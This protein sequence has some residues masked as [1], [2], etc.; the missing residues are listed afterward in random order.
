MAIEEARSLA[1][2]LLPFLI[3]LSY[4]VI[5]VTKIICKQELLVILLIREMGEL[6]KGILRELNSD[7]WKAQ[8]NGL[9]C[10]AIV[11][12]IIV[13]SYHI[14]IMGVADFSTFIVPLFYNLLLIYLLLRTYR[15]SVAIVS[16]HTD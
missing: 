15:K 12:C 16:I 4:T 9:V 3:I 5:E 8:L 6:I 1:R 7:N 11:L 10:T 2:E 14:I 13:A